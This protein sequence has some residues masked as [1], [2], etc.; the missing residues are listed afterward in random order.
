MNENKNAINSIKEIE[1]KAKYYNTSKGKEQLQKDVQTNSTNLY[2][3]V[4]GYNAESENLKVIFKHT[5]RLI[6]KD[7]NN[8]F[9]FKS[10]ETFR[11]EIEK[12]KETWLKNTNNGEKVR[13]TQSGKYY[14]EAME[15]L[16]LEKE[17]RD[18]ELAESETVWGYVKSKFI[19]K[20]IKHSIHQNNTIISI[21]SNKNVNA[22]SVD[23]T[24]KDELNY[25]NLII[26]I[27][28]IVMTGYLIWK[29]FKKK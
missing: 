1:K 22:I 6:E 25:L 8:L 13:N 16:K 11:K 21:P 2:N 7:S 26:L 24:E 5:D 3:E 4:K 17:S 23:E 10:Y 28:L 19:K 18:K 12:N 9:K 15:K 27:S 20:K 29:I 14:N